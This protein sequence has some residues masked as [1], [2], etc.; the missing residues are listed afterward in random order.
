MKASLLLP[1]IQSLKGQDRE[2]LIRQKTNSMRS[3]TLS[4]N[5]SLGW[6]EIGK[7]QMPIATRSLREDKMNLMQP[8][9]AKRLI[10]HLA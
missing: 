3:A 1:N 2:N 7:E 6:I 9:D 5:T 4:S 8:P 10:P